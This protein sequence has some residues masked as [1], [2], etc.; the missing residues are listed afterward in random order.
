MPATRPVTLLAQRV[1]TGGGG[2]LLTYYRPTH[3]ERTELSGTSFANWVDKTAN[4]LDD[5]GI[6]ED[7]VVA[8]PVLLEAPMHWMS[9]VWPFALWQRGLTARVVGRSDA[10]AS[11]LAVIGPDAPAPL[12]AQTVACS[13]HP[14]GRRLV[15]L[16]PDVTDYAGEALAQPDAHRV[17]PAP[18]DAEAW[19]DAHSRA[20]FADL[21]AVAPVTGRILAR[22]TDAW[23]AVALLVGAVLGGGSVVFVDGD[24]D[25]ARIAADE[26][27]TIAV[28]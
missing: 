12:G 18:P 21:D 7:S 9:C 6:D 11:D 25:V 20:T 27:A 22:P 19:V 5:L 16:P 24:A 15:G 1:R 4:L 2:A 8:L 10:M 13:L 3:G 28:S 17:A 26:R 14:W 23:A